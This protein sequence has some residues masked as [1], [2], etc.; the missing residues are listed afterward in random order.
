MMFAVAI[1]I[2]LF[3]PLRRRNL[4]QLDLDRDLVR[5]G[6]RGRITAL[7][8][9]FDE[10][11]NGATYQWA[12]EESTAELIEVWLKH[13]RPVLAEDGNRCLFAGT[14]LAARNESEFGSALAEMVEHEVGAKFNMHLA[15]HFSVVR[16]LRDHPGRS[17]V[18]SR[19][20]GHKKVETTIRFYAGLE[21]NAA[22][23]EVNRTVLADRARTKVTAATAYR[24]RRKPTRKGTT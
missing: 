6:P 19:L 13:Y 21:S 22:A 7:N 18:V 20:L 17:A 23:A 14:G 12:M 9:S 11:K 2:L 5:A 15:R 8:I 10:T 4:V 16:F 1:D 24:G 3:C